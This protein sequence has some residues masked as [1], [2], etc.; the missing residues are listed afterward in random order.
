MILIII[1]VIIRSI[2]MMIKSLSSYFPSKSVSSS[3]F[4]PRQ[5]A[6]KG[7]M[8]TL[9]RLYKKRAIFEDIS[10][11]SILSKW[12]LMSSQLAEL[13][14]LEKRMKPELQL[15]NVAANGDARKLAELLSQGARVDSCVAGITSLMVAAQSGH[16]EVCKLL[17]ETGK[18]NVK[19]T[20][21]D[22]VTPLLSAADKGHT[23]LCKLLLENGSDLEESNPVT[24]MTALH[25]AAINGHESLLQMLLSHKP[26][27]NIRSRTEFTP[28]H[29]A[30]QEGHL[31]CVKKLLQAGADPLLPQVDG[32]LPIHMAAPHNHVEVVSILIKEGGC[33]P[34]Q[35]GLRHCT[36]IN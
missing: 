26:N 18:A 20:T 21:P 7:A 33:S 34:D 13:E 5:A 19:E 24:Q 1:N 11:R 8:S 16:T 14:A 31:A 12:R 35:V 6:K 2:V 23:E 4:C 25:Y 27:I 9:R 17:L 15:V 10:K 22:G 29:F 3:E 36:A 28:L 32:A 30:S